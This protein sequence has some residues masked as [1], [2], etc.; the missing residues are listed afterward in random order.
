MPG[1]PDILPS[2]TKFNQPSVGAGGTE[3]CLGAQVGNRQPR[4]MP[5]A[6]QAWPSSSALAGVPTWPS[7]STAAPPGC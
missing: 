2:P 5:W 1:L 4:D 6:P 3:P 7:P